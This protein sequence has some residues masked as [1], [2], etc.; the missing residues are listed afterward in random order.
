ML[1]RTDGESSTQ[2]ERMAVFHAWL[3][4]GVLFECF[5]MVGVDIELLDFVEEEPTGER[6]V[7]TSQLAKY[8]HRWE[9]AE[10]DQ[11]IHIQRQHLR[12]ILSFLQ[13]MGDQVDAMI[14]YPYLRYAEDPETMTA[15]LVAE[16]IAMLGDSLMNA[17][18]NIWHHLQEDIQEI[19][20][21]TIRKRLRY[22]EP[23]TL[24]LKRLER[25]GWCKSTRMMMHRLVD[26]S[27]LYHAAKLDRPKMIT[28]HP[29]CTTDACVAMN[30][31]KDI[32][33]VQ[34]CS[35]GNDCSVIELDRGQLAG[36]IDCDDIPDIPCIRFIDGK[37]SSNLI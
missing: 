34:H 25:K 21:S 17:T 10:Q 22:C 24:S 28:A 26:C 13:G 20:G 6:S 3:F 37:A 18:K 11:P 27:G 9:K 4:F 30:V 2:I 16:S 12:G 23:S 15:L 33:A 1:V 7:T 5:R 36:I 35:A 32:Y 14:S 29:K 8:V 19:A 31:Q